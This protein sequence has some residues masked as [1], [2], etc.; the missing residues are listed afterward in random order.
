MI[1][2]IGNILK[3]IFKWLGFL[4]IVLIFIKIVSLIFP[5]FTQNN[6]KDKIEGS[7][8]TTKS[9]G[10]KL[11]APG[12]WS[13]MGTGTA[14]IKPKINPSVPDNYYNDGYQS[15]TIPE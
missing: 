4:I 3:T 1:H 12:S 10:F 9:G 7:A 15:P 11:P 5:W 2:T 13:I 14:T 6:I 8:T